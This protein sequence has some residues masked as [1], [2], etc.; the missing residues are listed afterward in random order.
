ML[1]GQK[2]TAPKWKKNWPQTPQPRLHHSPD[3]N[4]S[5]PGMYSTWDEVN[6]GAVDGINTNSA[7]YTVDHSAIDGDRSRMMKHLQTPYVEHH[8]NSQYAPKLGRNDFL[9]NRHRDRILDLQRRNQSL[10]AQ[11]WADK[12]TK[13]L[14][15]SRAI[16]DTKRQQQLMRVGADVERQLAHEKKISD[17]IDAKSK[18]NQ[19]FR[20]FFYEKEIGNQLRKEA[21]AS[22]LQ[23][24]R[25]KHV[26]DTWNRA[27]EQEALVQ[28][29]QLGKE[30]RHALRDREITKRVFTTEV[31]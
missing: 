23:E 16:E 1:R 3:F 15:K 28:N 31:V 17:T 18:I 10:R 20:N 19:N 5:K 7:F 22:W 2:S 29:R 13:A 9:M 27:A 8:N 26:V 14:E 11:Q 30:Y 24:K 25:Q 4:K 21:H 6:F 12:E